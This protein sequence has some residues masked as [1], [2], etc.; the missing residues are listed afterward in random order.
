M[1]AALIAA[2]P[3]S[4]HEQCTANFWHYIHTLPP[5]SELYAA[6]QSFFMGVNEQIVGIVQSLAM[7]FAGTGQYLW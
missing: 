5:L 7:F 4:Q 6:L 2:D 3:Q 1:Y